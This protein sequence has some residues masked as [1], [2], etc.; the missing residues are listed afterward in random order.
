MINDFMGEMNTFNPLANIPIG[1]LVF[2]Y[3]GEIISQIYAN[4]V[5]ARQMGYSV[6]EESKFAIQGNVLNLIVDNERELIITGIKDSIQRN[7]ILDMQLNL[8]TK[9]RKVMAVHLMGNVQVAENGDYIIYSTITPLLNEIVLLNKV[10]SL[11]EEGIYV[12][13]LNTHEL[14][15]VNDY[16]KRYLK[17]DNYIG[18]ICY[19]ELFGLD[20]ICSYCK[21]F[22]DFED[23]VC[24]EGYSKELDMYFSVRVEETV[25]GESA[26]R[27]CFLRDITKE[28]KEQKEKERLAKDY[29]NVVENNP[30]G[31]ISIESKKGKGT[32]TTVVLPLTL[33]TDDQITTM[34]AENKSIRDIDFNDM[35]VLL[36]EDNKV[37]AKV[38]VNYLK[39]AGLVT[40][41]AENGEIGLDMFINSSEGYYDFILMDIQMPVMNGIE[42]T[43]EIRKSLHN[44]AKTIPIIALSANIFE[45]EKKIA[46]TAGM[47]G[48]ISK[49]IEIAK[50]LNVIKNAL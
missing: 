11:S 4:K 50:L 25:W 49:P 1:I 30:G 7:E 9:N 24:Q 16:M 35:R 5:L 15:Y 23:G 37:N 40:E 36:F 19:K 21:T 20:D 28:R 43:K 48:Y 14:L 38:A 13:D 46:I 2:K 27:V 17:E 42:A 44:D 34:I 47:N 33:A 39:K 41:L 3:D 8:Y 32:T 22:K 6:D 10:S 29:I 31:T 12:V 45:E 26:A 18:K